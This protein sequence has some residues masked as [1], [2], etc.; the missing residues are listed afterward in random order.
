VIPSL[1]EKLENDEKEACN[2]WILKGSTV[3]CD[4]MHAKDGSEASVGS[5]TLATKAGAYLSPKCKFAQEPEWINE[6]SE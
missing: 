1:S 2:G 6:C 5:C 3:K 4:D